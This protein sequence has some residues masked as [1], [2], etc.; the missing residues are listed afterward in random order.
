MLGDVESRVV[1]GGEEREKEI[2]KREIK[3]AMKRLKDGKAVG[4]NET[5]ESMEV[6][7]RRGMEEWVWNFCNRMEEEGWPESWKGG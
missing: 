3:E 2:S 4:I 1:R 7:G 6:R 5:R